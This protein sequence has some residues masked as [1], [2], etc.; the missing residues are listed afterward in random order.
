MVTALAGLQGAEEGHQVAVGVPARR[1][2]G[3]LF[4]VGDCTRIQR[5]CLGL[6][7]DLGVPVGRVDGDVPQP[8]SNGVDVDPGAEHV[9]GSSM[10]DGMRADALA[11]QGRG[12]LRRFLDGASDQVVDT[13][14]C[15]EIT[16]NVQE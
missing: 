2:L 8:R 4:L 5:L 12:T 6:E 13:V 14:A 9:Y 1:A 7:I 10:P 11:A 16:P 3:R 15:D